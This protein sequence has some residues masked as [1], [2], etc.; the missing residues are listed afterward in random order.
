VVL[1]T[2]A[3]CGGRK[4]HHGSMGDQVGDQAGRP[5]RWKMFRDLKTFDEI[6]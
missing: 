5:L 1:A 2:L 3:W 4:Q 6:E